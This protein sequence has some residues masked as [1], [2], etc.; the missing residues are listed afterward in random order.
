MSGEQKTLE[1]LLVDEE[2]VTE[3][4]L[5][6]LLGDYIRI[7]RGS[8][9]LIPEPAFNDLK[10]RQQILVVLTAQKARTELDMVDV[11]WMSPKEISEASGLNPNTIYPN[12]RDMDN[13]NLIEGDDGSY[14]L[15]SYKLRHVREHIRGDADE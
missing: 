8:G 1:D 9:D 5:V 12:V 15:P 10:A 11:E 2:E 7:A 3:E 14:R 13:E 6:E 4:L